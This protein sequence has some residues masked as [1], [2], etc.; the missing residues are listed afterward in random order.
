MTSPT[1]MWASQASQ[2]PA[3]NSKCGKGYNRYI[4]ESDDKGADLVAVPSI[5]TEPRGHTGPCGLYQPMRLAK[6]CPDVLCRLSPGHE[7]PCQPFAL[8]DTLPSCGAIHQ[9]TN[10]RCM[11]AE[12]HKGPC[13]MLQMVEKAMQEAGVLD[14][15]PG[16]VFREDTTPTAPILTEPPPRYSVRAR[17]LDDAKHAVLKARNAS[18]GP[19]TQDFDRIAG[20]ANALFQAK[21]APGAAFTSENVAQFIALVKLSRMQHSAHLD[22]WV[23]LAGYAACGAECQASHDPKRQEEWSQPHTTT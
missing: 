6:E 8:P 11:Q 23:D 4:A 15:C 14:D 20:M 3:D 17:V 18:Y 9:A 12:G 2:P 5:C 22:N 10:E 1:P 21:L 16:G 13:W 19:P 7:G